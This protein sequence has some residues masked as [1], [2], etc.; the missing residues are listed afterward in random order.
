MLQN[1]SE[2]PHW[3]LFFP[4]HCDC[5]PKREHAQLALASAAA[6]LRTDNVSSLFTAFTFG[7]KLEKSGSVA[8]KQRRGRR[9]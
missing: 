1:T 9:G 2:A 7:D 5:K 6:A 4:H 8:E 3:L